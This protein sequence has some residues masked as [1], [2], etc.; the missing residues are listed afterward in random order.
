MIAG[1]VSR[2]DDA[3]RIVAN[4]TVERFGRLDCL[5]NNAGIQ[6]QGGPIIDMDGRRHRHW[7]SGI[8]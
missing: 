3:E 7:R 1:D 6:G 5:F 8:R 2:A 4:T